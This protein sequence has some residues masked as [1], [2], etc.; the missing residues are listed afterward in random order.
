[1]SWDP[2]TT[3]SGLPP[4]Q[5]SGPAETHLHPSSH[6]VPPRLQTAGINDTY[7]GANR[8]KDPTSLGPL[9]P[10]HTQ[11]LQ[12]SN[13]WNRSAHGLFSS[14][15][16]RGPGHAGPSST[17][18]PDHLLP[19]ISRKRKRT[20]SLD[21]AA[22]GGYGPIPLSSQDVQTE[23]STPDLSPEI[24]FAE[25][26]NSAYEIWAFIRPVETAKVVPADQWPDDYRDHLTK[27]PDAM[28]IGCKLCTQFG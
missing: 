25:R 13:L 6:P 16:L 8:P 11:P 3:P 12:D 9:P 10:S 28:F 19:S 1:M 2:P 7:R 23:P 24:K 20:T 26:K 21:S 27:R 18:L 17:P 14:Q 22:I 5:R 15:P 4:A